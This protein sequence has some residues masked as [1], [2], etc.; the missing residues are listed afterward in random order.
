LRYADRV[1][2]LG[3]DKAG[4]GQGGGNSLD[5]EDD[6]LGGSLGDLESEHGQRMEDGV[7]SPE[8]SDLAQLRSLNDGECSADWYNFQESVA[9][10]QVLEEDVVESHKNLVDSMEHWIQQDASLLAMTN[11]VDYDQ[12]A[13]AQQLEDMIAEKQEQLATLREKTRAF[14]ECLSEEEVQSTKMNQN[15]RH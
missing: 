15:R 13:Y 10:L 2:E 7:L 8:D 14:R 1:K 6:L 11:E 4:K 3:V 9:H 12:D 5:Y